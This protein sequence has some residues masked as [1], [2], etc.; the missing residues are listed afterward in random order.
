MFV[1][2]SVT[3][4]GTLRDSWSIVWFDSTGLPIV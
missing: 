2:K 4:K 3:D 1:P